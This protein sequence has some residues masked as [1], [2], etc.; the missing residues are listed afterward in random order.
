[1]C[2]PLAIYVFLNTAT[3]SIPKLFL[4][5]IHGTT[6]MGIFHL[7]NSPVM[8]LQVGVAFLFTPFITIFASN[9]IK[10]DKSGFLK[11]AVRI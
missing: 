1:E 9:L 2:L 4:E 7:V 6:V 10:K 8:I 3:A 5:R 11:I